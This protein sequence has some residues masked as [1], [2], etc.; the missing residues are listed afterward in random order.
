MSHHPPPPSTSGGLTSA[1][2][3]IAVDLAEV[4]DV[5]LDRGALKVRRE[6][7]ELKGR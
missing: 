3:D 2:L 4:L 6:C 7:R 5:G 1:A